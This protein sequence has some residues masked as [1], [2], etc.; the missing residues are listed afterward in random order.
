MG[1]ELETSKRDLIQAVLEGIAFRRTEV[2]AAMDQIQPISETIPI[3][4]GLSANAYFRQ[5]LSY[6][7]ARNA[8]VSNQPE[9]TAMGTA[10]L[11]HGAS[12][13]SQL[14]GL[15]RVRIKPEGIDPSAFD[16]FLAA[17]DAV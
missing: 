14:S 11:A 6:V 4:G 2:I 15:D 7:L 3:T 8:V 17:R 9:L 13:A 5:F 10:T 16:I 1:L 12:G